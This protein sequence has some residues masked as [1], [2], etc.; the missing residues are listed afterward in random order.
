MNRYATEIRITVP[1]YSIHDEKSSKPSFNPAKS[2]AQ[3]I[4]QDPNNGGM[5]EAKL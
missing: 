4:Y 5:K 1:W 3:N 2:V